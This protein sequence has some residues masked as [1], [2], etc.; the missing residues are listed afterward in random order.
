M[1]RKMPVWLLAL[2]AVAFVSLAPAFGDDAPAPSPGA[3]ATTAASASAQ[4]RGQII[5]N[6]AGAPSQRQNVSAAF[7]VPPETKAWEAI[8]GA[9]GDGN[10]SSRD[11]G[12]SLGIFITGFYGVQA[13]G[14]HY[15][16][17]YINGQPS[18]AGVSSYIVKDGDIIEFRYAS[19]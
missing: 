16:Q 14:N 1:A 5:I 3:I 12:G 11:F 18:Q 6:F 2:A 19:S 10:I 15:W 9:L 13:E 8:K 17:L 4:V 7:A